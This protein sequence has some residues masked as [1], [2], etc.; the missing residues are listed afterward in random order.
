MEKTKLNVIHVV[1]RLVSEDLSELKIGY[2]L[3]HFLAMSKLMSHNTVILQ[4]KDGIFRK[5]EY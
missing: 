1:R 2:D 4:S 5:K 3:E